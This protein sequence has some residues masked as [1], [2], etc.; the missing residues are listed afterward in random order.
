MDIAKRLIDYGF[1]PYTT[2]FPLIVP[3]AMMIEPT[4]SESKE[5]CDQF[6]DAMHS[7]A[8]EAATDARTRENGSALHPNR[9]PGRSGRRPQTHPPLETRVATMDVE[10]RNKKCRSTTRVCCQFAGI[11]AQ[12]VGKSGACCSTIESQLKEG[13]RDT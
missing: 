2:A 13:H 6:I 9:P 7:I 4:E 5:E 11:M 10:S 12:V 3:G 8:D 1:H